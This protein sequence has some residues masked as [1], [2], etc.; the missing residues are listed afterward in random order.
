[1]TEKDGALFH[2]ER[3]GD[4][5]RLSGIARRNAV[6][7]RYMTKTD[8]FTPKRVKSKSPLPLPPSEFDE[9]YRLASVAYRLAEETR[10]NAQTR[11]PPSNPSDSDDISRLSGIARRSAVTGRYLVSDRSQL[12]QD[13]VEAKKEAE[14]HN[15]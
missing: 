13:Q 14:P 15:L 10:R 12:V 8:Q 4:F 9:L 1:M 6:T 7:G 2:Q 11:R 5:F 3:T